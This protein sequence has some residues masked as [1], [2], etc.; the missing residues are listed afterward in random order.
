MAQYNRTYI[1]IMTDEETKNKLAHLAMKQK[2][3]VR[4]I[5]QP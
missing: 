4:T 1:K 3:N 5:R 2:S